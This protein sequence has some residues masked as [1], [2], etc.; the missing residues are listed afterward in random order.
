MYSMAATDY[1]RKRF[2]LSSKVSP[3]GMDLCSVRREQFG[4]VDSR[5]EKEP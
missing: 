2:V 1:R 3:G 4:R 5:M